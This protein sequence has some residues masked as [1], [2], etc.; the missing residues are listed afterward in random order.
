[1][2]ELGIALIGAGLMVSIFAIAVYIFF[3]RE[4]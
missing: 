2:M 4:E 3:G 1:M